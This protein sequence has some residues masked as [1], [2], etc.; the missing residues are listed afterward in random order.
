MSE[1]K[2]T[3]ERAR[4]L[5]RK[6]LMSA[7]AV[8]PPEAAQVEGDARANLPFEARSRIRAALKKITDSSER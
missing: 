5:T 7:A 2:T 8:K 1:Y 6:M 3:S 4:E